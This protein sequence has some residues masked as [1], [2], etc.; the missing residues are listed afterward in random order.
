VVYQ[1]RDVEALLDGFEARLLATLSEP[2]LA[3]MK[4]Y[5]RERFREA[6]Q[7]LEA[8][9]SVDATAPLPRLAVLLRAASPNRPAG[10]TPYTPD[11]R[12]VALVRSSPAAQ[13]LPQGSTVAK[14]PADRIPNKDGWWERVLSFFTTNSLTLDLCIASDPDGA[15]FVMYPMSFRKGASEP[16]NTNNPLKNVYRGLYFYIVKSQ[17][18]K[19]IDSERILFAEQPAR[20]D[21]VD[22][23][24]ALVRCELVPDSSGRDVE[25]CSH[26]DRDLE[27]CA[28]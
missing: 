16:I 19:T 11:L 20:L 15:W 24:G 23:S 27:E 3:A 14:E 7:E 25:P 5:V 12:A 10:F 2:E 26:E 28:Q 8:L 4:D 13:T 1:R 21:L 9:P 17:G 6:R 22:Q 18:Y